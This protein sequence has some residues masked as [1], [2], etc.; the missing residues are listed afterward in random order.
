MGFRYFV[1]ISDRMVE[2]LLPQMD[3]GSTRSRTWEIGFDL[4]VLRGGLTGEPRAGA[5]R[6]ERLERV[7]RWLHDHGDLGTVDQPGQ[8][9]WGLMPMRWGPMTGLDGLPMIY[10]GGEDGKTVVGLGGSRKH[11]FGLPGAEVAPETS[12]SRSM[13]PSLLKG[14]TP[15]Q[16]DPAPDGEAAALAA[17][18]AATT[19][20]RG[21]PQTM[22]FIAK[23]LLQGD[24]PDGTTV[25]LGSPLYVA[26]AD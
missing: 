26:Q 5:D 2:M 6:V 15:P 17:V 11:V 21:V 20:L 8:F 16:A 10:L 3:R 1:Y 18:H 23:R 19:G 4:K 12:L 7:V 9:V 14:I 24:G 13:L 22:E 25:L